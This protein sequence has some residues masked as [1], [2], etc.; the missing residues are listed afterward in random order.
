MGHQGQSHFCQKIKIK[1]LHYLILQKITCIFQSMIEKTFYGQIK[2]K[3]KMDFCHR[4]RNK[5][6][7]L[8]KTFCRET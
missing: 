5:F 8:I 2:P 1:M 7:F 3:L 4:R 6:V